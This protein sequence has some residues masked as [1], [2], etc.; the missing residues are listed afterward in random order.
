MKSAIKPVAV[1]QKE[2]V[3]VFDSRND[4][5]LKRRTNS[6]LRRHPM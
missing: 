6:P 5:Y 1:I 4:G 3:F 2:Q